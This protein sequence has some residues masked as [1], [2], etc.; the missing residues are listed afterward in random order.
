MASRPDLEDVRH[1]RYLKSFYSEFDKD[2]GRFRKSRG[3]FTAF[4]EKNNKFKP[5]GPLHG[6]ERDDVRIN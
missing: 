6:D 5:L 3:E 2:H 1:S 4:I